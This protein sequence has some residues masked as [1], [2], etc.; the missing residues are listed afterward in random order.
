MPSPAAL[1]DDFDPALLFQA[2]YYRF[3]LNPEKVRCYA[4]ARLLMRHPLGRIALAALAW[5]ARTLLRLG[6]RRDA[7]S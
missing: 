5:I 6:S 1:A 4:R 2:T 3:A 7:A